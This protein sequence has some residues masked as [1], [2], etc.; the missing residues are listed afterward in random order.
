MPADSPA[1][2]HAISPSA[3]LRIA[4]LVPDSIVDGPGLRFTVFVQGCP[5]RCDGCHNPGTWHAEGGRD[6]AVEEIYARILAQPLLDGVTLSGGEP[7]RQ[8]AVLAPLARACRARGLHVLCY[9]G[10]TWEELVAG[11]GCH[12]GRHDL[13]AQIDQVVDGRFDLTRRSLGLRF[14]GSTNQRVID[15]QASLRSGECVP[16]SFPRPAPGPCAP[17]DPF[18]LR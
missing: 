8:A 9:T 5:H 15:V 4:G 13:L 14:R 1:P 12:Q 10:Y 7:F 11:A 6:I 2:I 18:S 17:R 3:T 16:S